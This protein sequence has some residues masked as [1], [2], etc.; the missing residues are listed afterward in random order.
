MSCSRVKTARQDDG[1]G[2]GLLPN[3]VTAEHVLE[4]ETAGI[5][6]QFRSSHSGCIRLAISGD[7]QLRSMKLVHPAAFQ[8]STRVSFVQSDL[9]AEKGFPF[10]TLNQSSKSGFTSRCD[11]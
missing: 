10:H 8:R 3:D 2:D 6:C 11:E 9:L 7:T 1:D 4:T 5:S